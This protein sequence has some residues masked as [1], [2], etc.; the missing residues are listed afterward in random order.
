MLLWEMLEW[1]EFYWWICVEELWIS[2]KLKIWYIWF[3]VYNEHNIVR[4]FFYH[5]LHKYM[6]SLCSH[7]IYSQFLSMRRQLP[8]S[9]IWL[10]HFF[11]Y[12]QIKSKKWPNNNVIVWKHVLQWTPTIWEI[13]ITLWVY[14]IWI[15]LNHSNRIKFT[16]IH[17]C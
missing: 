9:N 5:E 15:Y 10:L 2:V 17:I 6:I 11:V 16:T 4:L 3:Y 7:V 14:H 8:F 13:L 1:L 12:M